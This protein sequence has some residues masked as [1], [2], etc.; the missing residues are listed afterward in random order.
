MDTAVPEGNT[1]LYFS[2]TSDNT[3]SF[4][5]YC[6]D[7]S[8]GINLSSFWTWNWLTFSVLWSTQT[9]WIRWNWET[10][11]SSWSQGRWD[12]W[13]KRQVRSLVP[14]W[15]STFSGFNRSQEEKEGHSLQ[16]ASHS[17][18][19]QNTSQ[20]IQ[21]YSQFLEK[22]G[23]WVALS[24]VTLPNGQGK[25]HAAQFLFESLQSCHIWKHKALFQNNTHLKTFI[26]FC[27]FF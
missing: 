26:I 6:Y 24:S 20:T 25:I 10:K 12:K 2:V 1:L 7:F 15:S 16:L 17:L 27:L 3:I 22:E 4:T 9:L 18:S 23:A 5:L 19:S 8:F 21:S 11:Q 13:E 14:A